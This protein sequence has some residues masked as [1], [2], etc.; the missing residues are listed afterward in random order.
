MTPTSTPPSE[1]ATRLQRR[2]RMLGMSCKLLAARSGVSL[3]T[4]QRILRDGGQHATYAHV[5]AVA[6]AMGIDIELKSDSSP[7]EF[8]RRQACERANLIVRMVQGTSALESQAVDNE[9]YQQLVEQTVHELMAG[10][11]GRLWTPM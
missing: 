11:K 5:A 7:Q 2:R 8:A 9:T 3:P 4:V 1:L 10:P 6:K